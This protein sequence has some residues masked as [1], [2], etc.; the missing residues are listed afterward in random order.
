MVNGPEGPLLEL[1][2]DG[3]D[4]I[5]WRACEET[6]RRLRG[7]IFTAAKEQDWPKVRNLQKLMVR[8]RANTLLSVRQATQR[9]AGRKTAGIDGEVAL[10]SGARADVA[11]QVHATIRSWS[12]RA[13][14]RVYIPNPVTAQSCAH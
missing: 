13:V 5:D 6:V 12:P 3:W 4:R 11:G 1:D 2:A 14:K 8:S 9:N 10:T 7:R